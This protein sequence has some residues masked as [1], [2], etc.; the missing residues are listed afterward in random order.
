MI[1]I[2]REVN[3][4]TGEIAV[5]PIEKEVTDYLLQYLKLKA[6]LN[7]ELRYFI[8]MRS[9][10]AGIWHDDIIRALKKKRVTVETLATLGGIVEL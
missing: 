10:W 3:R 1:A 8:T 9:R 6:T 7:P 5:Y 4:E 2:C